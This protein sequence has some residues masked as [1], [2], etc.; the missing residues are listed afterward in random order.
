MGYLQKKENIIKIGRDNFREKAQFP[1]YA[2]VFY[3]RMNI[4]RKAITG[5]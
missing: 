3:S 5:K 1:N 4:S 2:I